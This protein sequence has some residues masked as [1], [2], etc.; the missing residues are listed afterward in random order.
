MAEIM[1]QICFKMTDVD[2]GLFVDVDGNKWDICHPCGLRETA[3]GRS[4]ND[5]PAPEMPVFVGGQ[6]ITMEQAT[7]LEAA[8]THHAELRASGPE[9]FIEMVEK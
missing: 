1:C 5:A 4:G 2:T 9:P 7:E 6:A 8:G 3:A